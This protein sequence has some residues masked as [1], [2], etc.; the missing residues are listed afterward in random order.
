MLENP[1]DFCDYEE[2][3]KIH[4]FMSNDW[5]NNGENGNVQCW[6]RCGDSE[7]L[8]GRWWEHNLV[9]SAWECMEPVRQTKHRHTL[10]GIQPLTQGI[11]TPKKR[12]VSLDH[13]WYVYEDVT[14]SSRN[15]KLSLCWH[16]N[17]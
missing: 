7:L 5:K 6:W 1:I 10:G 11:Q 17:G 3:N 4:W 9:Q 13:M 14:G 12:D 8:V 15:W 2:W 16:E